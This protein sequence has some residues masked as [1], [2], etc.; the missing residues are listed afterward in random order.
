MSAEYEKEE[1]IGITGIIHDEFLVN[2]VNLF[3]G[4]QDR[5]LREFG[6]D[7]QKAMQ[8][9]LQTYG[10]NIPVL[11]IE[12]RNPNQSQEDNWEFELPIETHDIYEDLEYSEFCKILRRLGNESNN[13]WESVRFRIDYRTIWKGITGKEIEIQ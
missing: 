13:N 4:L 2:E 6:Q 8:N 7:L 3:N 5:A 1:N 12:R 9:K 10:F 11:Q